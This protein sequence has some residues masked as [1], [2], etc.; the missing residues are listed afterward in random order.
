MNTQQFCRA[1][2]QLPPPRTQ[3]WQWQSRAVCRSYDTNVFYFDGARSERE[4]SVRAAKNLCRTCPVIT[5]CLDH[6]VRTHE[7]HG[8][9]GGLTPTERARVIAGS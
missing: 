8:V 3:Y 5:E 4:T 6:A 1:S 7:P 9:W 2:V